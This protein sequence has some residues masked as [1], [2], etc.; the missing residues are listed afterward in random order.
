MRTAA[1]FLLACVLLATPALAAGAEDLEGALPPSAR[2]V[3]GDLT[4]D[5]AGGEGIWQRL[6][7]WVMGQLKDALAEASRSAGVALA[8]TLLCSLAAA[9]AEDGKAPEYI[10]LGGA[11][12]V[13]AASAGDIRSFLAQ[14]RSAL[15]ELQ[16]F[17]R[18]LLPT[19]T[20][21][22]AAMGHGA[23]A[24]AKYAA[25]ALF[26]DVLMW[27][28]TG[29]ILPMIY[30]YVAAA[31]ANA[32][33]P[34]GALGGPVKLMNCACG[35]LLATLTSAFTLVL[36]VTGAVS[37]SADKVA[38]SLTKSAISAALPVVGSILA[39]AADAYVAG[40]ALLRS[41]VGLFGL[42]VV[43]AVCAG[44]ALRLGLHYILF[45]VAAS[46]AEPFAE[47][48][49]AALVG[50]IGAAYGMALGLVGSAGAMLFV[51]VVLGAEVLGF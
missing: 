49:L 38:G 45:K 30:A 10:L 40:A 5:Q 26:M 47:G 24:A 37:G 6:S 27:A 13:M 17:S 8:V 50:Q 51:S 1:I 2:D 28:G 20:A 3:L 15:L 9:L 36:T 31:T 11:L 34:S 18:A 19:V 39:D 4:V 48:R 14:A 12:A 33:L 23:S 44:P 22:S 43:A 16:D 32:A 35:T 25:S 7:D 29:L 42:A 21:A 41:A 46:V